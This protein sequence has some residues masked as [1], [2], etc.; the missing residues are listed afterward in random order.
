MFSSLRELSILVVSTIALSFSLA[1]PTSSTVLDDE[2]DQAAAE[3]RRSVNYGSL[4]ER[5]AALETFI[6]IG[7]PEVVG[8]LAA[9]LR[10]VLT[11]ANGY[12]SENARLESDVLQAQRRVSDLEVRVQNDASFEDVLGAR[13]KELKSLEGKLKNTRLDLANLEPWLSHLKSELVRYT[14]TLG[15]GAWSK[16]EKELWKQANQAKE[17]KEQIACI[18]V[19]GSIGSPGTVVDLQKFIVGFVKERVGLERRLAKEIG[20]V[21]NLEKRL[22]D[23]AV[24]TGG[25][26]ASGRQYDRVSEEAR[27]IQDR[28]NEIASLC[29]AVIEAGAEALRRE[30]P[31]ERESSVKALLRAQKKGKD[32]VRRFTLRMLGHSRLPDV[33]TALFEL[34]NAEKDPLVSTYMIDALADP[35]AES[36]NADLETFLME[37]ALVHKS[38]LVKGCA[39]R[40]LARLR[41]KAAIP[42]LIEVWA[43]EVGRT[44]DE[45]RAAMRSLTGLQFSGKQSLWERWWKDNGEAFVLPTA[46]EAKKK[47]TARDDSRRSESGF[48]GIET[49][50]ER[51]LFVIDL[52]G[53]MNESMISRYGGQARPLEGERSRLQEAKIALKAAIGGMKRGGTFNIIFYA[54][55]VWSWKSKPTTTTDA[56][57]EA[58]RAMVDGLTAVGGT[59]VY[60]ALRAALDMAGARSID[61]WKEPEVDTIYFLSDG[62]P[63]VGLSTN[64]DKILT[65]VRERNA[66]AGIAIHTIGISGSQDAY[67]MQRLAVEN[68]GI[69]VSR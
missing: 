37:K 42:R 14:T 61:E 45:M 5:S 10:E 39:A 19:L 7:E 51:I 3:F 44:K 38:W 28:I 8:I 27:G 66:S 36:E 30:T 59:N 49:A 23:E 25:M 62:Q 1:A 29:E 17:P 4:E 22:Q 68:D 32:G 12:R 11:K 33:R 54:S 47:L 63:S 35:K 43:G 18:S 34:L 64:A 31:E 55:H 56:S 16:A 50:S 48:F 40:A 26:S 6:Q 52:S 2:F 53:S 60:G 9:E 58:A 15:S 20:A 67:L 13:K 46:E 41:T 57:V 21:I 69:Y 24:R 65:Y